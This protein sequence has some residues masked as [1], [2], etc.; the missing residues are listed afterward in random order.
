MN[1]TRISFKTVGCRLNQ[2]ETAVIR[3]GFEAAGYTIVPFGTSCDVCVIHGC[4]V[5]ANAEKDSLRLVRSAKRFNP[6][7]F[8]I[9]AGCVAEI[10]GAK[11]S[12]ACGA[13]LVAG[14][15][16]KFELPDILVSYGFPTVQKPSSRVLPSFDTTRAFVKIQD[17]CD[18]RCAYCIVPFARGSARS[19]PFNEIIEE[20][21]RLAGCGYK[22]VVLTGA[23]IGCY[24]DNGKKLVDLLE[25]IE[26]A[27]DIQRIR[28]S[29]I[30]ISTVERGVIDFMAGSTKLCHFLHLPLQSGSDPVLKEM[31]RR[32]TTAYYRRLI[33]YAVEKVGMIGLG[34]DALVGFPGEDS[35]A[36]AGTESLI[37]ELPFSNLHIFSYSRRQGTRASEIGDQVPENEKKERVKRLIALGNK[38]RSFFASQ[39]MGRQVSVLLESVNSG[40]TQAS[41]WTGE[42]LRAQVHGEELKPNQIIQFIPDRVDGEILVGKLR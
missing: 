7:A 20:I 35:Q 18:F 34:T 32:Y 1:Q 39:W 24:K 30:E 10:G 8:V 40:G 33:E 21:K 28:L 5:T 19:R 15:K 25:Q 29:S 2:A 38:K 13:D 16:E 14:Q 41:G 11:L 26:L 36:F 27:T 12:S 4:T 42:Y 22:E 23:N 31:G 3:A 6:E 37:A 17:G 9:L